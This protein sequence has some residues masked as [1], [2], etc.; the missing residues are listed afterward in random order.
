[1]L[2][3]HVVQRTQE[4]LSR[5]V[6]GIESIPLSSERIPH[7]KL[8]RTTKGVI[9]SKFESISDFCKKLIPILLV[10]LLTILIFFL[11]E[12]FDNRNI[13]IDGSGRINHGPIK[14]YE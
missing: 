12:N 13:Y 1:M 5:G 6:G 2:L 11:I 14:V 7:K 4:R 8:T 3:G 10:I 9:M